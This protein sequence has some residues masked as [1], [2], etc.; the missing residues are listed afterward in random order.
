[1]RQ[2]GSIPNSDDARR[3][4]DHLLTLGI[5]TRVDER[6]SGHLIW[7]HREEKVDQAKQELGEFLKDPANPRY[8]GVEQTAKALRKQKEQEDKRHARN[9]V[10]LRGMWNYRPIDRV[11]VTMLLIA[12]SLI[13]GVFTELGNRPAPLMAK[14]WIARFDVEPPAEEADHTTPAAMK[15]TSPWLPDNWIRYAGLESIRRGEVWR[16]VSPIFLHFGIWHLLFNLFW[17]NDLG[18]MIEIRRGTLQVL[19]LVLLT[20]VISNLAQYFYSGPRF[21]GMSGV[22]FGL[23]GYAWVQSH[24]LP[25]AGLPLRPGTE[26]IMLLGFLAGMAHLFGPTANV[27]HLVGFGVG[28]GYGA[29][30]V[31]WR[32]FSGRK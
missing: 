26:V 1:M 4:A 23:F 25:T 21:G 30:P 19:V 28:L 7:V 11:P 31:V 27:A 9:S 22:V 14:L 16:L 8:Q 20:A 5:T 24:Y 13:V 18:G 29:I 15:A 17:L 3:L 10:A 32:R 12:L 2:I 6:P